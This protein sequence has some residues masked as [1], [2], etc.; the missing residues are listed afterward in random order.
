VNVRH[1]VMV[2]SLGR[3]ATDFE[4]LCPAL[5]AAGFEPVPVEPRPS[6]D[7]NATLHDLARDTVLQ[8][9]ALGIGT[10]HLVGHAFGNR[11]SRTITADFGG[12][13][14]SLTLLAA[15]GLV[16]PDPRM[17]VLLNRCFD[18]AL[19][20]DEHLDTVRQ[21]FFAPGND[22]SVWRDGWMGE[23]AAYQRA[24]V[25]ATPREDWWGASVDRVLVVQALQDAIAPPGNGRR[26]VAESAPHA[27]LVEIDG[28]GHAM[29]P[30]RPELISAALVEFLSA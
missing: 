2:P 15:G 19:P 7:G 20:D 18:A 30:E 28:A 12:R 6:W 26:Y 23:V 14:E 5:R 9:D 1:V 21:V 11:L 29:I 25:L 4:P 17:F 13:V 8:L 24:A 27:R 10:F 16:E 3:P 22:P